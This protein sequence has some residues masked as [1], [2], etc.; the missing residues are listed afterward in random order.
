ML[1]IIKGYEN[2][3]VNELGEVYNVKTERKLSQRIRNGYLA[4]ALYNTN[5]RKDYTIHRLV[6]EAFL[7]NP[8]GLPCVNH[9]DEDKFNNHLDNLEWCTAQYNAEYSLGLYKKKGL[10]VLC[11]E[12][13]EIFNTFRQAERKLGVHNRSIKYVCDGKRKV[14]GGYHFEYYEL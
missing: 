8:E 4:V 11:Q 7:P 6:A 13:G 3:A 12:T 5:G 1:K 9:K 14:A 10:K 2:Y